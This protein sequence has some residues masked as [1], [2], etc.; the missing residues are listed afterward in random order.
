MCLFDSKYKG[1]EKKVSNLTMYIPGCWGRRRSWEWYQRHHTYTK[2][3]SPKNS[4]ALSC[5][6]CY[7][8]LLHHNCNIHIKLINYDIFL[9]LST[10]IRKYLWQSNT[11]E[12]SFTIFHVKYSIRLDNYIACEQYIEIYKRWLF[13]DVPLY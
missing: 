8:P 13:I 4:M 12:K 9:I 1:L 11:F 5:L 3:K 7:L 10:F 2:R 6:S